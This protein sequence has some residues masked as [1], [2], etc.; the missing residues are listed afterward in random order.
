MVERSTLKINLRKELSILVVL[1]SSESE[2]Q[3]L[4]P[5]K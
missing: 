5:I 4:G 3:I 1:K 2:F